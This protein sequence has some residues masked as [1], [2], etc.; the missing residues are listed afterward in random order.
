MKVDLP[1]PFGPVSPYRRP[2]ENV[3]VTS[4]KRTLDPNRIDT[5]WTEIMD[6]A[7]TLEKISSRGNSLLYRVT[8]SLVTSRDKK[9]ARTR[10]K[11]CDNRFPCCIG[12][13]PG[14]SRRLSSF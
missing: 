12:V 4:S 3:V 14:S 10:R 11:L 13:D 2:A 9:L 1:A 8:V 5:P 6:L 7:L